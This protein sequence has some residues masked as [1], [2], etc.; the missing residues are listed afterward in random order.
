MLRGVGDVAEQDSVTAQLA[1]LSPLAWA[2]RTYPW[3]ENRLGPVLIATA[4]ALLLTVAAAWLS[5]LRDLGAALRPVTPGHSTASGS[6][7]T[8]L[9]LAFR[10]NRGVVVSW[11][12][13]M[14]LFG[15]VYGPVLTEA[16]TFLD[17][18]PVLA[19]LLPDD[20]AA[21]GGT[22]LFAAIILT[23]A[24]IVAV[25]PA[26]TALSRLVRDERVGRTEALL[27]NGT[28]RLPW[29]GAHVV[30]ALIAGAAPLLAFGVTFGLV[31]QQVT[32]EAGLFIDMMLAASAGL[33]AV[34]ICVG[35]GAALGG[36]LPKSFGLAWIPVG[37]GV[38]VLYFAETL[39]WPSIVTNM[40]PWHHLA[41]RPAETGGDAA[42]LVVLIGGGI[43]LTILGALGYRSRTVG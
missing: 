42:A 34:T 36:I 18:M 24:A 4:V 8:P 2:Q 32:G 21:A 14:A 22:R 39:D 38:V 40:S 43:L 27:A 7:T 11:T 17:Q 23:L 15:T 28:K 29:F 1:L 12:L 35:L 10:L 16:E 33:T 30:V 26:L 31:G 6:L 25:A 41:A 9:G 5:N 3:D 20:A 13:A 19:E 37:I